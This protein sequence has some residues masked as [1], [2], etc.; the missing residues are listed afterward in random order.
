[1]RLW[2]TGGEEFLGSHFCDLLVAQGHEV[3]WLPHEY[4]SD[5]KVTSFLDG[6]GFTLLRGKNALSHGCNE[7]MFRKRQVSC[8]SS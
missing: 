8:E 2:I 7:Y 5:S 6:G 4:A 3:L 1:M